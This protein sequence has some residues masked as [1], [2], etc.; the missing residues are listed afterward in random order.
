[1]HR[2]TGAPSCSLIDYNAGHVWSA[3]S[4]LL[5]QNKGHNGRL[6]ELRGHSTTDPTLPLPPPSGL[7]RFRRRTFDA[8]RGLG[9]VEDQATKSRLQHIVECP[10]CNPPAESAITSSR[11]LSLDSFLLLLLSGYLVARKGV[12]R[13]EREG[14]VGET[15][16]QNREEKYADFRTFK[17]K[18]WLRL[19]SFY[20]LAPVIM[21][22]DIWELGSWM[23]QIGW[24]INGLFD[25]YKW[26]IL[27]TDSF[28]ILYKVNIRS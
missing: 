4:V 16:E 3:F 22:E 1:M 13:E 23:I 19:L 18:V 12:E 7:C 6:I 11:P 5:P 14:R 26:L 25:N 15:T 17:P 21:L 27:M 24:N 20:F 8:G 28:W 9:S 10:L 2:T